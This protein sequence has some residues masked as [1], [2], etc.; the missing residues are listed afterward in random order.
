MARSL[1]DRAGLAT[2]LMSLVLVVGASTLEEILDMLTEARDIGDELGDTE[3][4]AEAMAWRTPTFVALC[5]LESARK[6]IAALRETAE[7]TGQ[8]FVLHVVE[9]YASAIALCD[10]RLAEAER[11]AARSHEWSRLLT[12]RDASA[13]YGIQMFSVRREQGRLAELA[14]VVR[15]LAGEGGR[16]GPWCPGLVALLTEL[17]MEAEARREL[18]RLVAEGLDAHRES[19]W[20]TSLACFTDAAAAL[21]DEAA[22][23]RLSRVRAP[24]RRQ[25]DDRT[26]RLCYGAT[27]RYLGMLAATLGDE[28]G[29]RALRACARPEPA[30]GC[31]DVARPHGL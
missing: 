26:P 31:R 4:R 10:G 22:A 15:I 12:G 17:G 14:P 9:H 1:G 7:Q 21:G 2:V 28:A 20:F 23:A 30:H 18:G 6:E 8:P 3:I 24:R 27:D 11:L 19:L 13:F 5:D 29:S 25:H 16:S